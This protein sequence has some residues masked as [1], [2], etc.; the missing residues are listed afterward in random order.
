[1]CDLDALQ[2]PDMQ[3]A[4]RTMLQPDCPSVQL[5][6]DVCSPLSPQANECS[7]EVQQSPAA[8][9]GAESIISS[10]SNHS[11]V[12][13][14]HTLFA[15]FWR[16]D[17]LH[18]TSVGSGR[19]WTEPSSLAKVV[20]KDHLQT[21]A[22]I[23][24]LSWG[25]SAR[26]V[27]DLEGTHQKQGLNLE[28]GVKTKKQDAPT[29]PSNPTPRET[30]DSLCSTWTNFH[31]AYAQG[32]MDLSITPLIPA[33][34]PTYECCPMATPAARGRLVAPVPVWETLRA[35][36][37]FRL[38]L[39]ELDEASLKVILDKVSC[40]VA[41]LNV[42][43]AF[44]HC[45]EGHSVL[46]LTE[47]GLE[48]EER[49][50]QESLCAHTILNRNKGMIAKDLQRDWR[51]DVSDA[52]EGL[53]FYAGMPVVAA[54]G[55]PVAVLSVLDDQKH[56]DA[57]PC[58]LRRTAREIGQLFEDHHRKRWEAKVHLMA[59][60]AQAFQQKLHYGDDGQ[61][62]GTSRGMPE[63]R[64]IQPSSPCPS[65]LQSNHQTRWT[66]TKDPVD[67]QA[68]ASIGLLLTLEDVERL[69][70]TLGEMS[71]QVGMESIYLAAVCLPWAS[72]SDERVCLLTSH[73]LATNDPSVKFHQV[74]L[75]PSLTQGAIKEDHPYLVYQHDHRAGMCGAQ[76]EQL[77]PFE[78]QSCKA[79]L[80]VQIARRGKL[81]FVLGALTH[82]ESQVIGIEDLRYVEAMRPFLA[83]AIDNYQQSFRTT[84]LE[85]GRDPNKQRRRMTR[86]KSVATVG[87]NCSSILL[88]TSATSMDSA[89]S[90]EAFVMGS[91]NKAGLRPRPRS[92]RARSATFSQIADATP[93][94]EPTN[95]LAF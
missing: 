16:G 52:E 84:Q 30:K 40:C 18:G 90:P 80:I 33:G 19:I 50:R 65:P 73:N 56:I 62:S 72:S 17:K 1:M 4:A 85:T 76:L 95:W 53:C 20:E 63:H 12:A 87:S 81:A 2:H 71:L 57:Q 78:G 6:H 83:S 94:I 27:W 92:N 61:G 36:A 41:A 89:N 21:A 58:I 82:N 91:L 22:Q 75:T 88:P 74:F 26:Q 66:T 54:N 35:M 29:E 67:L 42:K 9:H 77:Y 48:R 46:K 32:R 39:K 25:C 8:F 31:V 45:L 13:S 15:R 34:V 70:T 10:R 7:T 43:S 5:F 37:Y 59:R 47:N 3:V 24:G 23:L 86:T 28:E 38:E 14:I 44:L 11:R 49:A 79:M 69:R 68:L 51:F 93:L 64:F 60:S 55:L